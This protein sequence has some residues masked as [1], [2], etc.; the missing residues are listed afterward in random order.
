MLYK[1]KEGKVYK[2]DKGILTFINPN[3]TVRAQL[4]DHNM[5]FENVDAFEEFLRSPRCIIYRFYKAVA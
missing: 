5:N 2:A 3:G 4:G 1:T